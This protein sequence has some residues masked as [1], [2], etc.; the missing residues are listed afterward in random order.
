MN[1]GREIIIY[2]ESVETEEN[3][4]PSEELLLLAGEKCLVT[5]CFE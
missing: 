3:R 2:R 1:S 5:E 4:E